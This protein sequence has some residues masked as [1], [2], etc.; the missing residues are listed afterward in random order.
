[1]KKEIDTI[2]KRLF[3]LQ[4]LQYR[5]FH[6]RL[7]PNIDPESVIGV[8]IPDLR[9]L[10]KEINSTPEAETFMQNLPHKYYEENNLHAFLIENIKDFSKCIEAVNIFLPYIDNWAT[11]DSLRPKVFKKN[12]TLLEKQAFKWID[13]KE[14]YT[15]RFGI[16]CLMI[17]FLDGQFNHAHA[18]KIAAVNCNEYYVGMM[19]A[20]YFAT[21]LAK[22]YDDV[23]PYIEKKILD[24]KTHKRTIRKAIDSY[25]ID[26]T[27]KTY[28]KTLR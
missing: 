9:Q 1:M 19:V 21:A 26:K 15:V 12:L 17:Y 18:D 25:R 8:R 3:E 14:T 6:S 13:S 5:D 22:H 28:L 16:E 23:L 11:C 2:R 7:M 4:D 20:W 27:Q 10:A 24:P